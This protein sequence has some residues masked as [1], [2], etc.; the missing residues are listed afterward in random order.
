MDE[1]TLSATEDARQEHGADLVQVVRL[2]TPELGPPGGDPVPLEGGITNR[3]FRLR[4]G[5][6]ECVIRIPGKDTSRLGIDREAE[7]IANARAARLGISPAVL[8]KLDDPACLV[9]EFV[10]GEPLGPPALREEPMLGRVAALLRRLH[11]DDE[12][13]PVDFPVFRLVTDYA[14]TARE[15]GGAIPD[16]YERALEHA[17]RIE[18]AL[19]HPEHEPVACHND[20]LAANFISGPRQ[21]WL[22]DWDYA[23]MGDRY[24]DLANFAIN[25]EISDF[26]CEAVLAAYFAAEGSR[27]PDR[28]PE[29][30]FAALRLMCVMSDFREAMWGV[31]QGTISDIDFDFADYAETHFER[32]ERSAADKRFDEWLELARGD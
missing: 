2:L 30:R 12:A 29:S 5:E 1:P 22:V 25:N 15:R 8:A 10:S 24:F 26:D 28:S 6:R 11:D 31:V 19:T 20:L 21:I 17:R 18:A 27:L 14:E 23:G 13:I 9:T 3:N 7:R 32:L 4:M 16:G